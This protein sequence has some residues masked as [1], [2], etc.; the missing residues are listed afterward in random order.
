MTSTTNRVREKGL[1]NRELMK[2]AALDLSKRHGLHAW[3]NKDLS[4]ATNIPI[5]NLYYYFRNR[6]LLTKYVVSL[7]DTLLVER[8][9]AEIMYRTTPK[10]IENELTFYRLSRLVDEISIYI[11]ENKLNETSK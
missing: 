8:R 1:K 6:E 5:G 4:E 9:T 7:H 10:S 11:L 2:K 3:T